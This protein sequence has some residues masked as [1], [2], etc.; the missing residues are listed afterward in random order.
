MKK[1]VVLTLLALFVIT[2]IADARGCGGNGFIAKI[3]ARLFG[4]RQSRQPDNPVVAVQPQPVPVATGYRA[5]NCTCVNCSCGFIA[6]P[7]ADPFTPAQEAAPRAAAYRIAC[8]P[9]GCIRVP[10]N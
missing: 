8:T 6:A 7:P 4:G 10:I 9:S 1:I 3:R 5:A 2:P